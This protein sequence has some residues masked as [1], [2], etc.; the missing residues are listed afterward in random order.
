[1]LSFLSLSPVTQDALFKTLGILIFF[2]LLFFSWDF[3]RPK[4][5]LKPIKDRVKSWWVIFAFVTIMIVGPRELSFTMFGIISLM[6]FRELSSKLNISHL[7]R[8]T[9][10]IAYIAIPVQ[11]Y[12][13]Y[14]RMFVPFLV[15]IP[16]GMTLLLPFR[17]ILEDQS[18]ESLR[19]FS[20][21]QWSLLLT[22]FSL[23]HISYL[24]SLGQ[25]DQ[26]AKGMIFFLIV[27]TQLNDVCQ[28]IFGKL[29]GKRKI[30]PLISPNKT[31]A[32]M[33]G[34]IAGSVALGYFFRDLLPLTLIQ[35]LVLAALI[36]IFGFFGDLNISAIKRDLKIKDMSDLI[37]G[38]G[39]IMDRV[40]SLIF[41]NLVFFYLIYY[42]VYV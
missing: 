11:F 40:D 25:D 24:M 32:G 3:V 33:L 27:I 1:M 36:A 34:G 35:T 29:F 5:F 31:W 18:E 15:F 19:T 30:S 6:A 39:G 10:R 12:F 38:H 2:T 26:M 4:E 37:P 21:L 23:S 9:L 14:A 22:V 41:S 17:S 13:A 42:W 20:Q 16:V 28:F 7:Q 8:R